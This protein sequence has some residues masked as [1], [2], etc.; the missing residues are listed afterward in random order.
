MKN[1]LL[2][3]SLILIIGLMGSVCAKEKENSKETQKQ[4]IVVLESR[5]G[6]V[7][8]FDDF[9]TVRYTPAEKYAEYVYSISPDFWEESKKLKISF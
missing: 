7:M 5:L 8:R 9:L 1:L 2:T 3:T 6:E 4:A